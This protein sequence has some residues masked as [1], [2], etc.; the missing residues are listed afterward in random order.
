[1]I[2]PADGK[3]RI[4]SIDIIR[5]FALLGI[6]LVNMPTFSGSEFRTYDG[7]DRYIRMFFDLFVQ[8]KFYLIFSFLFGLGFYLFM[9]RAE[10]KGY[11]K[12][13]FFRRLF[14]L[15]VI[16]LA[17]LIFLWKGD[18]LTLYAITGLLLPAF[19]PMRTEALWFWGRLL[20]IGYLL[21]TLGL[22]AII[23]LVDALLEGRINPAFGGPLFT[24]SEI[25]SALQAFRT[26][27]WTEWLA[28][29]WQVEVFESL[30]NQLTML[31]II[32]G[33]FLLGLAVGKSGML[34]NVE[35]HRSQWKRLRRRNLA[36][37]VPLLACTAI[38][39]A[40]GM[41]S[42]LS[43]VVY[44][45]TYISGYTLAFVYISQ[46][47]LLLEK[48]VWQRRLRFLQPYGRMALTN[49]LT[50]TVLCVVLFLGFRLYGHVNVWQG[51]LICLA[52]YPVQIA[53]SA[54]WLRR[55]RYG[56]AEWVWR[57]LTYA[58]MADQPGKQ[59]S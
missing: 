11:G 47:A 51:A 1:M 21:L 33:M 39:Y 28:W 36:A 45:I 41:E 23:V 5:G 40:F 44:F 24:A 53:Y 17:H 6:F 15:L 58:G 34:Q 54:F 22:S 52:I 35:A 27:P 7:A 48:P 57:R 25:Q 16:G 38:I 14:I 13:L 3:E 59:Q 42:S 26:L 18:I 46:L 19:Y 50:Q 4:V 2:G 49:Y 20:V 12:S 32:L 29:H 9:S 55:H 8:G 10:Q 37:S 56:P 30:A 43:A 31:P